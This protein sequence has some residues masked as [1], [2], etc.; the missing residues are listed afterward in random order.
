MNNYAQR[1]LDELKQNLNK[2]L[3][4]Y[5]IPQYF[6]RI[7]KMPHTPNG[8]IDRKA[9]PEPDSQEENKN[10]VKARNELDQEIMN[11][12]AKMLRIEQI[13]LDD[14][15]LDL[16]GDS[17]TAITLSTKIL[18][19]YNVQIN[20]K[21][22]ISGYTIK[23]IS[24]YI[25]EN[26]KNDIAKIKIEK[27]PEQETYPLSSAQ[28]RIYYNSK[29]I[30]DDNLVYNM[31]GGIIV[32]EI[33]DKEK[34]KN[35]FTKII[36][37]HSSLRTVFILQDNNVVQKINENLEFDILT[38]H[39]TENE[40][41]EIIDNF[42]KPF[43][44]EQDL[45]IRVEL[46]YIDNKKTLLLVESHHAIMD[47]T[48]LNNL[49]IEFEILYN[50]ENLKTIPIQYKDYAVWENKFNE[51]EAIKKYEEYWTNKFKDSEFSQLNLPYDYN[52]SVNRSYKG[53]K[54]S[55]KIDEHQFRK[56]ERYAKKI[57][58]SP[59][60]LF[61]SAFFVLLYIYTGQ[62]EITL[63]SPIANRDINET[64][65]MIGMF[66]NNIV[67]KANVK[68]EETFQ[69]F[70]NVMKEQILDDISNQP[71]PFDMLVK[72]LGIKAD[73]SRNPLFDV[74]FTYQNKEENMLHLDEHEVEV[75]E[76]D[77]NI[78]KFNLSLEI[79][80]KT[81]TINIEYCTDLF[82]KQTIER[83]FEHYMNVINAIV[84]DN[85]IKIADI[86]I[87]S[88]H[89]KNKILYEF[90]DT[91]MEYP[92][93][94]NIAQIFEEKANKNKNVIAVKSID[95]E[96]TY[97]ELNKK[98]NY[99]ANRLID[100]GI[101]KGDVIGI[102]LNRSIELV[103]A[104]MA[105]LKVG[106]IYMPMQVGYPKE[107]LEYMLHNSN[108]KML[109]YKDTNELEFEGMQEKIALY[110]DIKEDKKRNKEILLNSEEIAYIIYTSG[111]TGKP[112][113]VQIKH[114]NLINFVQAFTQYYD[115]KIN[116]KDE[117]KIFFSSL[118][119]YT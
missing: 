90:N 50:G 107:R 12:I 19:K 17:L 3:P 110:N 46:H 57:G 55:N 39:N 58:V 7:D 68:P 101:Q 11:I 78:A 22:I 76:I 29:M 16:G 5:M 28:K 37:R 91:K 61:I 86:S 13:S 45:L 114:S 119:I 92:K 98:S 38:Y 117:E 9:L 108:A 14:K 83:M 51:S 70:L 112:K 84:N 18:S 73:N 102:N 52:V 93:E 69:Q 15:L 79:K 82:K 72:K 103:I 67:V 25:K 62:E 116:M 113:G 6:M 34:V 95:G 56:I 23:D 100:L 27:A 111:S 42:S 49:I 20:I 109:M 31:P 65:R 64:K 26:K 43:K 85:N 99:L 1:V 24:D 97:E 48:A 88:E 66:V 59:Y 4:Q 21:D 104:M 75:I 71:Y 81:H 8:K 115:N 44:L 87:I 96:I 2:Q 32:D 77:N 33:L 105:V 35:A 74:M 60:M 54:I 40:I 80:P 106:A 89:E 41:Q 10:I 47:G 94:K 53:N 30:G 36:E 63:G 118:I